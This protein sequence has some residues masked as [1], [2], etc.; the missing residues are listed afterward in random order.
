VENPEEIA[1]Q[2]A[3]LFL[4]KA[5]GTRV[6]FEDRA[7]NFVPAKG[8]WRGLVALDLKARESLRVGDWA[9]IGGVKWRLV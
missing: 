7:V 4:G 1:A 6:Q 2:T 3:R 5:E 9:R 8:S